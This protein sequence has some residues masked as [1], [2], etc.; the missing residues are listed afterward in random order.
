MSV[1]IIIT[2][3]IVGGWPIFSSLV[4]AAAARLGFKLLEKTKAIREQQKTIKEVELVDEQSQIIEK[5]LKPEEE[6]TFSKEGITVTCQKDVRD[7]FSIHVSGENRTDDELR[8]IGQMFLN[9][10]KQQYAYQTVMQEM[11]KRGYN[12]VQEETEG[13]RIKLL[14]RKF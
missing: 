1:I 14:L 12:V 11:T 10:I 9:K 3:V 4:A 2:P 6:L 8:Q 7:K 13:Q 5:S